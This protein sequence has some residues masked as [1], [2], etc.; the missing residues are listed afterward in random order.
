MSDDKNKGYFD[1]SQA[2]DEVRHESFGA[3]DAAVAGLKLFGKGMF[4]AARFAVTEVIP[5]A[6]EQTAR[7]NARTSKELLKRD[8]LTGEQRDRLE[9]VEE[10]RRSISRS[11][12][13]KGASR[14]RSKRRLPRKGYRLKTRK[15]GR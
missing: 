10:N 9:K 14:K 7:H 2:L 13:G 15:P 5:A 12:S 3:K 6:V 4:N 11:K 8:D 1:L